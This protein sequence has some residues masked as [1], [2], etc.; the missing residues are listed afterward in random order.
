MGSAETQ[1]KALNLEPHPEGGFYRQTY[2]STATL[3]NGRPVATAILFLLT[4]DDPSN[5]HR[6][7]AEE[8]WHYYAGDPL[9]VHVID[10]AG[11][12]S[13]LS[14][15]PDAG[16][17]QVFQAVVPPNVWF[18]SSVDA[19]LGQAKGWSLVGCT[20]SPGFSF[21]G[22]ELAHRPD[23]LAKFP[24]YSDIIKRLTPVAD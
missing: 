15:G 21:D 14:I 18:G 13:E 17:G 2:V 20:V 16:A 11:R 12:Y 9:T 24:N 5:F 10:E 6:L 19:P 8:M 4:H 22:F 3:D 23:L 1:I 7:D